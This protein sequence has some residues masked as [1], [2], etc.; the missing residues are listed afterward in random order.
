LQI[1]GRDWKLRFTQ[2]Q[3]QGILA[4]IKLVIADRARGVSDLVSSPI[5]G[6]P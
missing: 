1:R 2:A 3:A 6:A 5:V 4:V